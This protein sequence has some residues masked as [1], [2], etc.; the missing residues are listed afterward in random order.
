M[1]TAADCLNSARPEIVYPAHQQSTWDQE[2]GASWFFE[3]QY[4]V[5]AAQ[6]QALL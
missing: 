5:V 6:S 2:F 4:L 1:C 3:K